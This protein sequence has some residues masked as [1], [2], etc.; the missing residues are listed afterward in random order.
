MK[1]N[2]P[3]RFVQISDTH[4]RARPNERLWGVDVDASLAAVL[5][6]IKQRHWPVDFMLATGDL[7]HDEGEAYSRL[8]SVL[9]PLG[10]PV[11]CLPGNHDQPHVLCERLSS[12]LVR[13]Q[14]QVINGAWQFILL[15]STIPDSPRGHLA[16][17]ELAELDQLLTANPDHYAVICLHHH[18]VLIG[19]TW[20]DTMVS[21]GDDLFAI[22]D[23]HPQ[24]RVVLWGHIHQAFSARRREV[25]L[26][27][28]PSTCVQFK[29]ETVTAVADDLP[30]GYRWF[31]LD[32]QGTVVTG[33][34]RIEG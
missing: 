8:R 24:V 1:K 9:E 33:I 12:G 22:L 18:P 23:R 10:V 29:P 15:D 31:E 17:S 6:C 20:L 14:R 4:L 3:L 13:W 19:S 5:A 7:V 30:P 28:V 2:Q 32:N 25:Q 34:E 16:E 11:Y 21:N 27:G 26:L